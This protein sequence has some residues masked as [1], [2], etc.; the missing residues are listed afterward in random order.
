[1]GFINL[2]LLLLDA[3]SATALCHCT[4]HFECHFGIISIPFC[5]T[6]QHSL[7]VITLFGCV[8]L[9]STSLLPYLYHLS[10][11]IGLHV[12]SL[13]LLSMLKYFHSA[14]IDLMH[15]AYPST[16]FWYPVPNLL[17]DPLAWWH[18]PSLQS[19]LSSHLIRCNQ[20]LLQLCCYCSYALI[21]TTS[22]IFIH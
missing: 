21:L 7:S 19:Q 17:A 8:L 9:H 5:A 3:M 2:L 1:M 4:L 13:Q 10:R 18:L 15:I 16:P 12:Y 22:L 11:G 20:L 14:L 6:V